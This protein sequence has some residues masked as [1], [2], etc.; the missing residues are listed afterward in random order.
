MSVD[1]IKRLNSGV[2]GNI[3]NCIVSSNKF[4]TLH[5]IN[6]GWS[7]S[8]S[9]ISGELRDKLHDGS[10]PEH[11][12]LDGFATA[13]DSGDATIIAA[14]GETDIIYVTSLSISN[15]TAFNCEIQI[16]DGAT[17]KMYVP[18]P[19]GA[20]AISNLHSPLRLSVN[21]PLNFS[22]GSGVRVS[23]LGYKLD[24]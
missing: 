15:N 6:S 1:V 7:V 20:G 19:A 18:A 9:G 21:S 14:Q 24:Y 3:G 12:L 22:H 13:A 17:T 8:S 10:I 11:N 2:E 16:K 23:A 4:G 5:K